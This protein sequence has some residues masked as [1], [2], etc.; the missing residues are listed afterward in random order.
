MRTIPGNR[1]LIAPAFAIKVGGVTSISRVKYSFQRRR[2]SKLPN[3]S[4]HTIAKKKMKW[5]GKRELELRPE[6]PCIFML[7][8]HKVLSV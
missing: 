3:T 5:L 8:L 6:S 7:Y 4:T 2:I 1:Y